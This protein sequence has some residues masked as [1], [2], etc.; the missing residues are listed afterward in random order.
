[1]WPTES[2]AVLLFASGLLGGFGHCVAMCGPVAAALSLGLRPGRSIVPHLLYNLGRVATY[3]LIGGAAGLL[4]SFLGVAGWLA[5]FQKAVAAGAGILMILLALGVAGWLPRAASP[6]G[7]AG[8]G[9]IVAG[10]ARLVPAG[11]PGAFLPLGLVLGFLPCG[12]VYTALLAAAREGMEAASR[13]GGFLRGFLAMLIFGAGTVPSL[14]L[15]GK[16]AAFLGERMRRTLCRTAGA[17]MA[18]SGAI[19]AARALLG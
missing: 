17:L 18:V 4:G 6:A 11:G 13:P 15:V 9:G 3:G 14:L 5:P 10:I 2:T 7:A 1:M 16:A 12:L 19:L 8:T